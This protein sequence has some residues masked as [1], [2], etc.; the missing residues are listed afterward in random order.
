MR[1]LGTFGCGAAVLPSHGLNF[2]GG[3]H[4]ITG[5]A[6]SALTQACSGGPSVF[7]FC[8]VQSLNGHRGPASPRQN[9]EPSNVQLPLQ[10]STAT[11]LT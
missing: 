8:A 11:R 7:Q 10:E 6:G 3:A 5:G 1:H 2:F 4:P 9:P